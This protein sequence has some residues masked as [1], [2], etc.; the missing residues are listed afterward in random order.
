[1]YIVG[2]YKILKHLETIITRI[3]KVRNFLLDKHHLQGL[4]KKA[5]PLR[6]YYALYKF[7]VLLNRIY[8]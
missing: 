7:F 8:H 4:P 3:L 2:I 1:M 5:E 6:N